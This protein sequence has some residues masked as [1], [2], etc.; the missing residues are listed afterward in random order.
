MLGRRPKG[1]V[2]T[3]H[4]GGHLSDSEIITL[5]S[6]TGSKEY[7]DEERQVLPDPYVEGWELCEAGK[8]LE[9]IQMEKTNQ[10]TA[11]RAERFE[12]L[13]KGWHDCNEENERR[14]NGKR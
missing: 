9:S 1:L 4:K 14:D 3:P 10:S 8:P 2:A 13:K 5:I 6:G 7:D 11:L 12:L